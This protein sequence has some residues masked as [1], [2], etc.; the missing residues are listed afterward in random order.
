M[1]D[2]QKHTKLR[3]F[4]RTICIVLIVTFFSYD[5]TWAGAGEVFS[6]K[7]KRASQDSPSVEIPQELGVIKESYTSKYNPHKLVIHIQDAHAN[8]EA[9]ENEAKL[10]KYLKDKYNVNLVSVEGGFGDFDAEFFRSFPKDKKV[11]DKIA[12]YFLSKAFI[13]G[14]DYLLI[15]EKNPPAVY[16]AE[17]RELYTAHL[18]TFKDNQTSADSLNR[19]LKTLESV[20]STLKD[21]YYS[22][23]LKELD[24][25]ISDFKQGR[26]S[27]GEYLSYLNIAAII[28][29]AD[30]SKFPNLYNLITSQELEHKINFEQA[31]SERQDLID[32]LTKAL[33]K[34]DLED[35]VKVSLDFKANKITPAEYYTYLEKLTKETSIQVN[36]YNNLFTYIKYI[37]LS[38]NLDNSKV[39]DEID[40]FTQS[41][42]DRL[43]VT[44]VQ[45]DIDNLTYI[46]RIFEG[47]ADINLSPKEYEHF[48]NTRE[49]FNQR[50]LAQLFRRYVD[51]SY[52]KS[53]PNDAEID[54]LEKF[55]SLAHDR[56]KAIVSNSLNR[57]NREYS[58][59]AVIIVAGGF[60]TQGLTSIL[61]EKDISYVVVAPSIKSGQEKE[62]TYFALLK[63]KK[64]PLSDILNDPDTLQ[65]I[66]SISDPEA[67][68]LL[69]NYWIAR[70]SRYYSVKELQAQLDRLRL[71]EEDQKAVSRALEEISPINKPVQLE[72]TVPATMSEQEVPVKQAP[73]IQQGPGL[74]ERFAQLVSSMTGKIKSVVN[75][76][77]ISTGIV[78]VALYLYS[79]LAAS[80][81]DKGS[82]NKIVSFEFSAA[83]KNMIKEEVSYVSRRMVPEISQHK[84][85]E[86]VSNTV[87]FRKYTQ[88]EIR[89]WV[90]TAN[91]NMLLA[92]SGIPAFFGFACLLEMVIW[93]FFTGAFDPSVAKV[94]IQLGTFGPL[95]FYAVGG[96]L[97]NHFSGKSLYHSQT[98]DYQH[99]G[100]VEPEYKKIVVALRE[101]LS[102]DY[103]KEI[104][105]HETTHYLRSY[106]RYINDGEGAYLAS[107]VGFLRLLELQGNPEEFLAANAKDTADKAEELAAAL[108]SGTMPQD[109][110][111]IAD[112]MA[113]YKS[114]L[115][116]YKYGK[117]IGCVAYGLSV[118]TNNKENSWKFLRFLAQGI[119]IAEAFNAV[120]TGAEI[121]P[122]AAGNSGRLLERLAS[123][124]ASLKPK[125]K[126]A[127]FI[128]QGIAA[129]KQEQTVI[130]PAPAAQEKPAAIKAKPE[131]KASIPRFTIPK[132]KVN[133]RPFLTAISVF[134]LSLY[135]STTALGQDN[136]ASSK[137][138]ASFSDVFTHG[139]TIFLAIAG[140]IGYFA[141]RIVKKIS[142]KGNTPVQEVAPV[143]IE[144]VIVT[145]LGRPQVARPVARIIS[146]PQSIQ[147]NH[148]LPITMRQELENRIQQLSGSI[149]Q[150]SKD[151]LARSFRPVGPA[152]LPLPMPVSMLNQ[153]ASDRDKVVHIL[154]NMQRMMDG[155]DE[156]V[157]R[158]FERAID[159]ARDRVTEQA[160]DQYEGLSDEALYRLLTDGYIAELEREFQRIIEN[161]IQHMI[162]F[163]TPSTEE[164]ALYVSEEINEKYSRLP[165]YLKW[166]LTNNPQIENDPLVQEWIN[167]IQRRMSQIPAFPEMMTGYSK[168][169]LN[170]SLYLN[171]EIARRVLL[172]L[173]K[174]A[175]QDIEVTEGDVRREIQAEL[176]RNLPEDVIEGQVVVPEEESISELP[177]A[178]QARAL[179]APNM[180]EAESKRARL[181]ALSDDYNQFLVKF[182]EQ[183][184]T[185]NKVQTDLRELSEGL[186]EAKRQ[187]DR[188]VIEALQPAVDGLTSKLRKVK[189]KLGR[190]EQEK[191]RYEEQI[192]SLRSELGETG[193][194]TLYALDPLSIGVV[195]VF[196]VLF[197]I[198]L[199]ITKKILNKWFN[200]TAGKTLGM[201]AAIGSLVAGYYAYLVNLTPKIQEIFTNPKEAD[202][203]ILA[204]LLIAWPVSIV[205]GILGG[206][207]GKGISHER[208][209]WR[210][211]SEF[212]K[213]NTDEAISLINQA[214]KLNSKNAVDYNLLAECQRKKRRFDDAVASYKKSL[215]ITPD[216]STTH[217]N[218]GV[219]YVEKGDDVKAI[220]SY[221]RSLE[222]DANDQIVLANLGRS[223]HKKGQLLE[224][225]RAF[226]RAQE[227]KPD[228][229]VTEE[230]NAILQQTGNIP[231]SQK[232]QDLEYAKTL[233]ESLRIEKERG[234]IGQ[235]SYDDN[236]TAVAWLGA[237]VAWILGGIFLYYVPYGHHWELGTS[238]K[239][240]TLGYVVWIG[241]IV[242]A[243]LLGAGLSV[244]GV[245]VSE[246]VTSVVKTVYRFLTF[247][248][249][250]RKLQKVNL[251]LSDELSDRDISSVAPIYARMSKE[252]LEKIFRSWMEAG[253]EEKIARLFKFG[254]W[255]SEKTRIYGDIGEYKRVSRVA[256]TKF[257]TT[258]QEQKVIFDGIDREKEKLS[259]KGVNNAVGLIKDIL[260]Q[261]TENS[262]NRDEFWHWLTLVVSL[263]KNIL[264]QGQRQVLAVFTDLREF[265]RAQEE[266]L[267]KFGT[268]QE[269]AARARAAINGLVQKLERDGLNYPGILKKALAEINK[270]SRNLDE[271]LFWINEVMHFD[272][273]LWSSGGFLGLLQTLIAYVCAKEEASK[274]LCHNPQETSQLFQTVDSL[275]EELGRKQVS[276]DVSMLKDVIPRVAEASRNLAEFFDYITVLKAFD[277]NVWYGTQSALQAFNNHVAYKQARESA[278]VK[279]TQDDAARQKFFTDI[280]NLRN[281]LVQKGLPQASD[282]LKDVLPEVTKTCR[283]KEEFIYWL[284]ELVGL[285][286]SVWRSGTQTVVNNFNDLAGF[287]QAKEMALEKLCA[288]QQEKK[289][290][291]AALV[292]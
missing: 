73:A 268:N 230:L 291:R 166:I 190:L 205:S 215:E 9:Q 174:K 254:N 33:N 112:L 257:A 244:A 13:S 56:D 153:D 274:K 89:S 217:N 273:Q 15:T 54:S 130:V 51:S 238:D 59:N 226:Q 10:I 115:E 177:P 224:A 70:A 233:G 92:L 35:L 218:L 187:N 86:I 109:T 49:E 119:D 145:A 85:D 189:E 23:D 284:G 146:N 118:K 100:S 98:L 126:E 65:I 71:S 81:F 41:L 105:A 79:P 150:G 110:P 14:S 87:P 135:F 243:P 276:V 261:I 227:I 108:K 250:Y 149:A 22:K 214:I 285:N 45:K 228:S 202:W 1:L 277:K 157:L 29:N 76:K 267:N 283:S 225:A 182:R 272:K 213:G 141:Y 125:T 38:Q 170:K 288:N 159:N 172:Y 111:G 221:K 171:P 28:N 94:F 44:G 50:R 231:K 239:P 237:V 21:R 270:A 78:A 116:N 5:L 133:L 232:P 281:Q 52:L 148:N 175:S 269:A 80:S 241:E 203:P 123:F 60:H 194:T 34:S 127:R 139:V 74:F 289:K 16:G 260:P 77:N 195:A 136:S 84:V 129:G 137:I 208:L 252:Y 253:Q 200:T 106:G 242:V 176:A 88:E 63:D 117:V 191:A 164:Q 53:L 192:N 282:L 55:Y 99:G 58:T 249:T 179:P 251:L 173:A 143:V 37:T 142:S 83:Q 186:E 27:L 169:A 234:W 20:V 57:L 32:S 154:E 11:R 140:T 219:V 147:P 211:N 248:L 31:E 259:Q 162:R 193:G 236:L 68:E 287:R 158:D 48:K 262:R 82:E 4:I 7:N 156:K 47:L 184:G 220:E 264:E 235:L 138:F 72:E 229:S 207:V 122:K 198:P 102:D 131:I 271:F 17:D 2:W 121:K 180:G 26:I 12:R 95:L 246:K 210:A 151:A 134:T 93:Y 91:R 113:E 152:E 188:I 64:L 197:G 206:K 61:K 265:D 196:T 8:V 96:R 6:N 165:R 292:L 90:K 19:S 223:L 278:A 280:D 161:Q 18:N 167:T 36:S 132:V 201:T 245:W 247:P 124:A 97:L 69:V 120:L 66:N 275:R 163:H 222:L 240:A 199:Y 46:I 178:P 181:K 185:I 216:N 25:K 266:S 209:Y 128:P 3:I 255:K 103:L 24:A 144:P 212:K 286:I 107:A 258:A 62:N 101:H 183:E 263:P 160:L 40:N 39:F 155:T 279:F 168:V 290:D 114:G 204:T 104:I 30:L 42:K 67:R 43:M 75:I 256:A